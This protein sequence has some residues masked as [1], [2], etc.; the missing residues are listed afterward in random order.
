MS[1]PP[2]PKS[3]ILQAFHQGVLKRNTY[4]GMTRDEAYKHFQTEVACGLSR[5]FITEVQA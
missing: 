5:D 2:A 3:I 1:Q 4:R